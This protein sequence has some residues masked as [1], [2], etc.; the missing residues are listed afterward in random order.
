MA[1]WVPI[2]RTQRASVGAKRIASVSPLPVLRPIDFLPGLPVQR[3]LDRVGLRV[4][5]FPSEH[6]AGDSLDFLQVHGDP[7][8]VGELRRP[9]GVEPAIHGGGGRVAPACGNARRG[10]DRLPRGKAPRR[11]PLGVAEDAEVAQAPH[12]F[13]APGLSKAASSWYGPARFGMPTAK[14]SFSLPSGGTCRA[15]SSLQPFR[16][17]GE[18]GTAPSPASPRTDR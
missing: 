15:G 18:G 6:D 4:G 5:R 16:R 13:R 10:L 11:L 8:R 7:L 9:A 14:V 17:R 12:R 1:R 3:D 2:I